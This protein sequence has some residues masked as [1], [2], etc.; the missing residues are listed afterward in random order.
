MDA[1]DNFEFFI[2]TMPDSRPADYYL[3]CLDGC[4]FIDFD[5]YTDKYVRLKRISF[6]GYG[7][8][9]LGDQAI[10]V[11]DIDSRDLKKMFEAGSLDQIRLTAIMKNSISA[12][13]KFIWEDALKEYGLI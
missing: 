5:N 13:K 11:N 9:T 7:C 12:N 8:C 2:T 6:D 10:P 4:V 3:G 1:N